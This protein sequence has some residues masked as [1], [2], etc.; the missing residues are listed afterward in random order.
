MVN[1][2]LLWLLIIPTI[3]SLISFFVFPRAKDLNKFLV[4]CILLFASFATMTILF[5]GGIGLRTADTQII[6]GQII[7]KERVHGKYVESYDCNCVNQTVTSGTGA[8]R[9]TST[10]QVCQTC[11]RDHFTVKWSCDSNIG[12]WTI[13]SK[14]WTSRAVYDEPDPA[15]YSEIKQGD[16]ASKSSMYVNYI[17]A[18]PTTLFR[19]ASEDLKIKYA[20][21]IP[22]YPDN[23]YDYYKVNRVLS[24]G[25]NIP[26]L[27]EWNLELS[28][29]LRLLGPKKQANIVIVVTDVSNPEYIYALQDAWVNGK[30]NDIIV[31]I[32]A[33]KFPEKA[34]WVRILAFTDNDIFRVKLRDAILEMQTLELK[35]TLDTIETITL[36]DFKRKRMSDFKYLEDEIDPPQW[37][38]ALS[39]ILVLMYYIGTY[40]WLYR[41]KNS[42]N[43]NFRGF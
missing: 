5:F 38:I 30:K 26:N 16:P 22:A 18:V 23:V 10:V 3:L 9:T 29:K 33:P 17:K 21:K 34:E 13:D 42:R 36:S 28:N 25:V 24:A 11:Y 6:N 14:D 7:S 19:P 32:G 15:R 43:R 37:M 39:I 35:P 4:P 20:N 40:I 27:A 12:S 8:N 41:N 1:L 31:V 2:T